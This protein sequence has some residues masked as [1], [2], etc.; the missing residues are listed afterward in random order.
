LFHRVGL[1]VFSKIIVFW[2]NNLFFCMF[3]I[4]KKG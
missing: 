1:S 3:V 4:K 2:K